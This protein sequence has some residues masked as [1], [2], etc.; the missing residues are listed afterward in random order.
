MADGGVTITWLGHGTFLLESPSGKRVL[1]DPWIEGNPKFPEAWKDKV[2]ER[3]DAIAVT[4]GHFDHTA[5]V[6]NIM[7]QADVPVLCIFDMVAWLTKQGVAE[8]R[9]MG[10][11][12][13]GTV[14]AAGVKFTMVPALHS[15]SH[16]DDDG[17]IVY[18]GE[19]VGYVMQFEDGTVVYHSGDTCVFGDMRII[20]ELYAPDVAILPIGGW[21]TMDP[22][23]AAY[24]AKLLGVKRVIPEHYGTFPLLTGTPAEL[25]QELSSQNIEVIALEPGQSTTVGKSLKA[26]SNAAGA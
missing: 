22:R 23:Q 8:D 10:F 14:E 17:N 1:L 9:C 21:F 16:T 4:H 13:G 15:S 25:Q 26:N 12:L 24:A 11:N 5:D 3:L 2:T 19:P 20:G 6:V 7:R 18:L